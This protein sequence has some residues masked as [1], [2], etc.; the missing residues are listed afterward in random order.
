MHKSTTRATLA[1]ALIVVGVGWLL[2]KWGVLSS[3]AAFGAIRLWPLFLILFGIELLFHSRS[4]EL[5]VWVGPLIIFCTTGLLWLFP[6]TGQWQTNGKVSGK[7]TVTAAGSDEELQVQLA[8]GALELHMAGADQEQITID[9]A[10]LEPIFEQDDNDITIQARN[11]RWSGCGRL[12]GPEVRWDMLLPRNQPMTLEIDAGAADIS[13][14]LS[15]VPLRS[16]EVDAGAAEIHIRLPEREGETAVSFDTGA[17]EITIEVPAISALRLTSGS[18]LSS[19]NYSGLN[20][21]PHGDALETP[22]YD[23][24]SHRITI[25]IDSAVSDVTIK[26]R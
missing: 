1:A 5:P 20:L 23:T 6:Q 25:D 11:R 10:G 17:S 4:K 18:A 12:S 3:G 24:S 8:V 15:T 19:T 14:D 13:A 2:V 26:R 9:Y 21:S 7:L 16:L 22:D